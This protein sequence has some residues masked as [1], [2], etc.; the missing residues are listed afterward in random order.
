MDCRMQLYHQILRPRDEF[1][2]TRNSAELLRATHRPPPEARTVE[3]HPTEDRDNTV[4][5][6]F[7]ANSLALRR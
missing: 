4:L 3:G 5:G 2:L 1:G 7:L 6:G